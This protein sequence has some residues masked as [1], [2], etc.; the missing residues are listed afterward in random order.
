MRGKANVRLRTRKQWTHKRHTRQCVRD[1]S[2]SNVEG[3]WSHRGSSLVVLADH[4]RMALV[5][6]QILA[7]RFQLK[8]P[9]GRIN[10]D[11][12]NFDSFK[13]FTTI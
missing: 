5:L 4:T 10:P 12:I 9:D 1:P 2:R 7:E 3:V 8:T 6:D 11:G 13:I